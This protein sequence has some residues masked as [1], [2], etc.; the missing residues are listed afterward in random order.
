[1]AAEE[2]RLNGQ[3]RTRAPSGAPPV[4]RVRGRGNGRANIAGAVCFRPGNRP[5]SFYRLH[6]YHGRKG[7]A[8]DLRLACEE[9]C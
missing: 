6:V 4:A 5:H 9:F 1:M 7:R 3:R 2:S 8:E